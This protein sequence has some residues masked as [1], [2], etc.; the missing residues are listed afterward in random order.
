LPKNY[1]INCEIRKLRDTIQKRER[2][3]RREKERLRERKR[4]TREG[5]RKEREN[6]GWRA[7]WPGAAWPEGPGG[8]WARVRRS[9]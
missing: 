8:G 2:K 3:L 9:G 7:G 6:D 1:G 4:G 5:Q